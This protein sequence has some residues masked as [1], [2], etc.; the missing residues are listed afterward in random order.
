MKRA[1]HTAALLVLLLLNSSLSGQKNLETGYSNLDKALQKDFESK[2][3]FTVVIGD[4]EKVLFSK[5][6][7][8][9]DLLNKIATNETTLFNI[10]S[11]SKSFTSIGI[12]HLVEQNKLKLSDSLGKFFK[13]APTDKRVITISQLLC[14]KSGF[15]QNFVCDGQQN[16]TGALKALLTDTLGSMPGTSFDYSNENFEM[17]ALVIEKIS[18][19]TYEEFIKKEILTPLGL[20]NTFFWDEVR[21]L[22]NV[23]KKNR[24]LSD[25]ITKRN[26]GYIG[27]GGIYSTSTDLYRFMKSVLSA[28][29]VSNRSLSLLF[30]E[31]HKTKGGLGIGYGWFIN[32]TTAWGT[33]E[34]WTRGNEDWGHNAVIRWFP[35]KKKMII[36]CT[37]SGELVG[38]KHNTGNRLI[39]N[40]ISDLLWKNE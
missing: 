9:I 33:K 6:Y 11:V 22:P 27:S 24:E 38:D 7:G 19:L 2:F 13:N 3:A 20:K 37:N 1:K 40:Y 30:T 16:P 17:L 14:H 35:D 23:A 12:L 31:H 4:E 21:R 36:V 15:Q 28:Q 8:H 18:N 34:I 25:S 39:S 5:A 29:I 32:D 26:W 10:A